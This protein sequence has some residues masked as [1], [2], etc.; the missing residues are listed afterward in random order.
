MNKAKKAAIAALVCTMVLGTGAAALT[1]CSGCNPAKSDTVH[2]DIVN[3]GFEEGDFTGWKAEGDYAFDAEGVVEDE[4]VSG[5]SVTVGGKVGKYYFNGLAAANATATGTLTGEPFKLGG[6]GKI[7]FKIGSGSDKEKCYVEFIEHG[8]NTVLKKVSNEAYD[9]GFIDDD[10]VRVVVDLSEHIGKNIYIKVT[11]NGSTQKSHEY[12]HLDDFVMY[13]TD[14]E[15][16]AANTERAEY[17]SAY[18]RPVFEDNTPDAKTIKN[19]NFENG[20]NNWLVLEGDAYTPSAIQPSTNKF[21]GTR[22][23]N[24]EGDYFLDG[25]AVGEDKGGSIRST[26][27]T[28]GETGIISFLMGNTK[29]ASIYLAVCAAEEIG[30]IAKDTELFKV[31][32]NESFR[33]PVY[34]LNLLRRYIDASSY[35]PEGGEAVNLIGKKL[36][37]KLVD[38]REGDDFGAVCFDDI[39]CSMTEEEVLALEKS[40]YEWAMALTGRGAEEISYTQNYYANYNYPVALPIMRFAQVARGVAI[41]AGASAVDTTQYIADVKANYG[42]AEE[43]DFTYKITNINYKNNNITEDFD[44]VVFDTAG[45]A[46]VTYEAKYEE[47]TLEATFEIEITNEYQISNGGFETGDL[48]GWTYEGIANPGEAIS[49]APVYWA[50]DHPYNQGGN[51]H[52]DSWAAQPN[53]GE[54][55]WLRSTEFI[56]GGSGYISFKLGGRTAELHVIDATSGVCL[57]EYTNTNYRQWDIQTEGALMTTYFA[58]LSAFRGITL[59]IELHDVGMSDWGIAFFDDI[60]TYYETAPTAQKADTVTFKGEQYTLNWTEAANSIVPSLVQILDAPKNIFL[61]GAQTAYNL[62]TVINAIE[63]AVIGQTDPT[64]TKTIVKV[65][66]GTDDITS[67]FDSLNLAVGTYTVTYKFVWNDG[68]QDIENQTTLTINVI[69]EN[70]IANGG[71]E[72]GDLTGWTVTGV[73]NANNAVIGDAYYWEKHPYNQGGN[74]HFDS[75][76]AQPNE[77]EVFSLKS[78]VFTLGGSG[79][80]SFKIGGRTGVVKVFKEDGTQI[81]EYLNP[82][83]SNLPI[84]TEGAFMSTYFADLS[85]YIG[86][87][88]YIE[89]HDVGTENWGV[90]FFDD[91][92]TYYETAPTADDTD[93][94]TFEGAQHSVPWVKATDEYVAPIEDNGNE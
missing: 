54:V 80:I 27:F 6:T 55:F 5:L 1:G 23:Y 91:I 59:Y 2:D 19:G 72:T 58:D 4:A 31:C 24:A 65:S 9:A 79:Y 51:Y 68:T 10:L 33:D 44:A 46:T 61:T 83:F 7:G 70:E 56:L 43:S 29:Y 94:V 16:T 93:T 67:G 64:I 57:A 49:A 39:R 71:F 41:K 21:W 22:E 35:T 66:D 26:T 76:T 14:A 88:L 73:A 52:F 84:S 38:G 37:I 82:V 36:Y 3:G 20:L 11:D 74:Y 63:G 78:T 18:G 25:F 60:V 86:E 48:S 34:T 40:D 30:S 17:I 87:K 92:V 53:E 15:V 77:G 81:A 47:M 8:T 90:A 89:L 45:I 42:D 50:E 85:G 75:W 69:S 12:F 28:L 13:K 32:S 62:E